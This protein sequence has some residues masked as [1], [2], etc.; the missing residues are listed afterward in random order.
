MAL[1]A[2]D[3]V[4]L[5]LDDDTGELRGSSQIQVALGGAVLSEL[6]IAGRV[7]V[8]DKRGFWQTAKVR[9]LLGPPDHP[10]LAEAHATI[11]EK[12][13]SAQDL[14]NRLG[15]GLKDRITGELVARGVLREEK[16]RVLGLFPRTRWPAVDSS[17]EQEVRRD[18]DAALLQG[19]PPEPRTGALISLLHAVDQAH[20]VIPHEGMSNGEV[21]KRAKAI[22]DGDW[23]A[24]G[25]TDAIAAANAAVTAAIAASAATTAATSSS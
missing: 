24:K 2:E 6:A 9:P 11:S 7:E 15:K 5:L 4:L 13:R 20:K 14:V 22:A 10:L 3:L 12:E 1:I 17:H 18:V 19:Q 21:K 16:D 23:A 25:V 8:E